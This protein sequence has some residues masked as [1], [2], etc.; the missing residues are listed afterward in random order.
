MKNLLFTPLFFLFFSLGVSHSQEPIKLAVNVNNNNTA[1]CTINWSLPDSAISLYDYWLFDNNE[2]PLQSKRIDHASIK[3]I[4]TG[5]LGAG[6]YHFKIINLEK[7]S[8]KWG[9]S[10]IYFSVPSNIHCIGNV[11]GVLKICR[12]NCSSNQRFSDCATETLKGTIYVGNGI[13]IS[14]GIPLLNKVGTCINY[15][16]GAITTVNSAHPGVAY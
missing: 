11:N 4:T 5:V 13:P 7:V 16:S 14:Q 1:I 10:T 9:N 8:G 6:N 15:S 3:T 2:Q 12:G